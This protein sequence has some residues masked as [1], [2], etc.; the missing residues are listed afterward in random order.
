MAPISSQNG[1][2]SAL[3]VRKSRNKTKTRTPDR[4]NIKILKTTTNR[5]PL[6]LDFALLH[7]SIVFTFRPLLQ[8]VFKMLSKAQ[9]M[10]TRRVQ[11][12]AE[13]MFTEH[14]QACNQT[15]YKMHAKWVSEWESAFEVFEVSSP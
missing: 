8:K 14:V 11:Q 9:E 10:K 2:P 6:K 13:Q 1:D 3:N 5:C 15:N 4:T 12:M 7:G